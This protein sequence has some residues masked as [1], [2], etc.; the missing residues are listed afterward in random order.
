MNLDDII[1]FIFFL[2][3][4][5]FIGYLAV[6]S[7]RRDVKKWAKTNGYKLKSCKLLSF[8]KYKNV[9]AIRVID[10]KGNELTGKATI[11]STF[12]KENVHVTWD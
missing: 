4:F 8:E 12:P 11:T 9:F 1:V 6:F 2:C 7:S 5:A 10:Q 3:F